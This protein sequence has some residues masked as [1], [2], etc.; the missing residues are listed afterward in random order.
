MC[1]SRLYVCIC[2]CEVASAS[3]LSCA[4]CAMQSVVCYV[5]NAIIK[6]QSEPHCRIVPSQ[7]QMCLVW[8]NIISNQC[9][10]YTH[11]TYSYTALANWICIDCSS[12]GAE[13]NRI[14]KTKRK[15]TAENNLNTKRKRKIYERDGEARRGIWN[16]KIARVMHCKHSIVAY[17]KPHQIDE[18]FACQTH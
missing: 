1:A 4:V 6:Q 5:H 7:K 8:F 16:K 3:V 10:A 9:D 14:V 18:T 2:V 15:A 13:D 17:C 12:E 11:F